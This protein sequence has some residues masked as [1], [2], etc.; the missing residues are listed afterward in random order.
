MREVLG[1]N[2]V[3]RRLLYQ[4]HPV[5][6]ADGVSVNSRRTILIDF[7]AKDYAVFAQFQQ[8]IFPK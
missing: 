2:M 1:M 3:R 7:F 5:I 4:L 6:S 8:G